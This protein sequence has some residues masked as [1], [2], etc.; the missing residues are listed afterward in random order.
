MESHIPERVDFADPIT[1]V[2]LWN[3]MKE[4]PW[5]EYLDLLSH[6]KLVAVQVG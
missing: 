2:L 6:L 1:W 4:M 5:N 3:A